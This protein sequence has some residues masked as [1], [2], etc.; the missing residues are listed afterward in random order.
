MSNL[1]KV[2]CD[3]QWAY[4]DK[5]HVDGMFP[6]GKYKVNCAGLSEK[7]TEALTS[8]GLSVKNKEAQGS[9]VTCKSSQP[10]RVYALD[11][12]QIDGSSVG[13]GSKGIATISFYENG[14][15]KFPQL[16]KLIITELKE[17]NANGISVDED[18]DLDVL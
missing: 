9:F 1:V 3:L 11:G 6:D 18:S 13:N 7:A 12:S 14:Y 2:N 17:F 15:G 8:L 10:I 16:N 5:P 4:L